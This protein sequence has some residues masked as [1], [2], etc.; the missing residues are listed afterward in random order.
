MLRFKLSKGF[1]PSVTRHSRALILGR[2]ST[3]FNSTWKMAW[4]DADF[5]K[6]LHL[7]S[8][9]YYTISSDRQPCSAI[10]LGF[11]NTSCHKCKLISIKNM[12]I[13]ALKCFESL[14][15]WLKFLTTFWFII[16]CIYSILGSLP[17]T[18]EPIQKNL[19]I[20]NY[21]RHKFSEINTVRVMYI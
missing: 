16:L 11:S 5:G 4:S 6:R 12:V 1:H 13:K 10:Y 8:P 3:L 19:Y 15:L 14:S 18:Y 2:L 9:I 21:K 17:H 20:F 7:K